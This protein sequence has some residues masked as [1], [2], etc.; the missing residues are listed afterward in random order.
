MAAADVVLWL[1]WPA[2]LDMPGFWLHALAAGRATAILDLAHLATIPALDPRTWRLQAPANQDVDVE[3]TAVTVSIDVMDE[4][5]SLR[6]ALQRLMAD[7]TLRARLGHSA[8]AYWE[9]EHSPAR[10]ADGYA[11]AISQAL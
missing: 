9:K 3:S 8:R 10:M 5:H 7:A 11:R 2:A 1:H 6:L 4:D